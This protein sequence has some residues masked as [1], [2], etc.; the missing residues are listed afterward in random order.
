MQFV[1]G[2]FKWNSRTSSHFKVG[3]CVFFFSP[4]GDSLGD[5]TG[6]GSGSWLLLYRNMYECY[7]KL[8]WIPPLTDNVEWPM[9]S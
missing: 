1:M 6:K 4:L 2:G 5:V 3:K 9:N 7:L 8:T